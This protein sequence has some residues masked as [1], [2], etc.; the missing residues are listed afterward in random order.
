MMENYKQLLHQYSQ[1]H[2]NKDKYL[3]KNNDDYWTEHLKYPLF[4]NLLNINEVNESLQQNKN[5]IRKAIEKEKKRTI[6]LDDSSKRKV[7]K[8]LKSSRNDTN[9]DDING[10][11]M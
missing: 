11:F 6:P 1:E 2:M 5:Q 10:Y 9:I 4:K 7:V 3:K 8:K